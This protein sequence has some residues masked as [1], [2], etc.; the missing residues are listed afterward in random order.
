[1]KV[2]LARPLPPRGRQVPDIAWWFP[3][4]SNSHRMG[5][6]LIDGGYVYEVA[7]WYPRV[8]VYDDVRGW[9]TEQYLGQGEFYLEYGSFD[10]RPARRP[11]QGPARCFG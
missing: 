1:M 8:A 9:N 4:G 2:D 11:F 3:F 7:Q 5:L 6:K 10:V